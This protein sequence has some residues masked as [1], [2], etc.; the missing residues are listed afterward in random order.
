MEPEDKAKQREP[1]KEERKT[2]KLGVGSE[3]RGNGRHGA[4]KEGGMERDGRQKGAWGEALGFS[5]CSFQR[6]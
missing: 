6:P 5:A 4:E 1:G 3:I 2:N